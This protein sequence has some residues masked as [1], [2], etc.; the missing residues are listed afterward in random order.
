MQILESGLLQKYGFA[1]IG[2]AAHPEGHPDVD[3]EVMTEALLRKAAWASACGVDLYYATQFCFEADPIIQWERRIRGLLVERL[4][5][6]EGLPDV[7]LGVAGPAK[8]S[9]LIKFA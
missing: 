6:K 2:V 7:I 4:G 8:Y 9:T 5:K 3:E 1:R